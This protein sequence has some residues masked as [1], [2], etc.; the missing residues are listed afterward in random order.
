MTVLNKEY[1]DSSRFFRS[2]HRQNVVAPVKDA[3]E[4]LAL[5]F[6]AIR[7][8]FVVVVVVVL[9]SFVR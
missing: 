8:R 1:F 6:A 9:M 4:T 7:S 3:L 2:M 5:W